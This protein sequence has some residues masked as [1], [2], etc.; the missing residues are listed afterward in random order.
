MSETDR[1]LADQLCKVVQLGAADDAKKVQGLLA[2]YLAEIRLPQA[3]AVVRVAVAAVQEGVPADLRRATAGG[4]A[5]LAVARG[6][7][8]LVDQ[9][10]YERALA[11]RVVQAWAVALGHAPSVAV[12]ATLSPDANVGRQR[13]QSR[14][15]PSPR[16]L[17]SSLPLRVHP[18]N[19][20][21][22]MPV[23]PDGVSGSAT[24]RP[25][26]AVVNPTLSAATAARAKPAPHAVHGP[27]SPTPLATSN[28][29]FLAAYSQFHTAVGR[30][31]IANAAQDAGLEYSEYS[32]VHHMGEQDHMS[33]AGAVFNAGKLARAGFLQRFEFPN[34]LRFLNKAQEEEWM[35][36]HDLDNTRQSNMIRTNDGFA[37]VK[38]AHPTKKGESMLFAYNPSARSWVPVSGIEHNPRSRAQ[39]G[40]GTTIRHWGDV[41]TSGDYIRHVAST[42][43]TLL[44]SSDKFNDYNT[45]TPNLANQATREATHAGMPGNNARH[46]AS[47]KVSSDQFTRDLLRHSQSAWEGLMQTGE[48]SFWRILRE[49]LPKFL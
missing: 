37:V 13:E 6:V 23:S 45:L 12:S 39:G 21:V 3:G 41:A 2:D 26:N 7:D 19:D 47:I 33:W 29:N 38:V 30:Q 22:S 48:T 4:S 46:D 18:E 15:T 1:Q 31:A 9:H 35:Q 43:N 17:T 42:L 25:T 16:D 10:G 49:S 11:T 34:S 27:N 28:P 20:V 40:N 14:A 36:A 8:R 24:T 5:A 44:G 32:G